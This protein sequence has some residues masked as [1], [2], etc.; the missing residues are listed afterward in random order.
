MQTPDIMNSVDSSVCNTCA[1][2]IPLQKV[3]C[4]T[5]P[6]LFSEL[7]NLSQSL[8]ATGE[9]GV[10]HVNRD[11]CLHACWLGGRSV[12]Q[13]KGARVAPWASGLG[14]TRG[15]G[16]EGSLVLPRLLGSHQMEIGDPCHAGTPPLAARHPL[17]SANVSTPWALSTL[18]APALLPGDPAH[19]S[20][21]VNE[22]TLGTIWLGVGFPSAQSLEIWMWLRDM[23]ALEGWSHTLLPKQTW[24]RGGNAAEEHSLKGA[25]P[26]PPLC[27]VRVLPSY[28]WLACQRPCGPSSPAPS[29][30]P[31]AWQSCVPLSFFPLVP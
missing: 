10:C 9:D 14:W 6:I 23:G 25:D 31:A 20:H 24:L 3:H 7:T 8:A 12:D 11:R 26:T 30:P 2:S 28:C 16:R 5:M 21:R 15:L 4:H 29:L 19:S 13:G 17:G 1:S 27:T 18:S 22:P